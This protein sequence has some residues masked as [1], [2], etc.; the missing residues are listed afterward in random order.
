LPGGEARLIARNISTGLS[1]QSRE[2]LPESRGG[3]RRSP[4]LT[5]HGAD[6]NPGAP[7]AGA[8]ITPAQRQDFSE[9]RRRWRA[10]D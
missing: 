9:G 4:G 3:T 5:T 1:A 10:G 6:L 8:G 2:K 7:A